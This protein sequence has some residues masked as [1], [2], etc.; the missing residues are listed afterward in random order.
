MKENTVLYSLFG[1]VNITLDNL[2]MEIAT[3]IESDFQGAGKILS[4]PSFIFIVKLNINL[5]KSTI[6]QNKI[7]HFIF[8]VRKID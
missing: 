8:V 2:R 3:V 4:E 5:I 1:E 7:S 6:S